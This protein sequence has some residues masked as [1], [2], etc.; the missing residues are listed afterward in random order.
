MVGSLAWSAFWTEA[1]S[2]QALP[3]TSA[4]ESA[5][6]IV[7]AS[8]RPRTARTF[9]VFLL[10][11]IEDSLTGQADSNLP[12][13][14]VQRPPTELR[15]QNGRIV[16]ERS[17]GACADSHDHIDAVGHLAF[18]QRRQTFHPDFRRIDVKQLSRVRVVHVVMRRDVGIVEH[19]IGIHD[20][21]ADETLLE[22]QLERVV[23]GRLGRFGVALV[24]QRENSIGR[25][26]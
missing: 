16:T 4:A 12:R 7:T 23:Y 3:D 15:W 13:K 5:A 24:D 10:M 26:M 1:S 25:Q 22:K 17:G 21:F 18:G 2:A 20:D 8:A 6:A 19:P 9:A 11:L 14:V